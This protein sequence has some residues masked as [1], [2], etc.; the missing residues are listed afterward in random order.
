M[1]MTLNTAASSIDEK[2]RRKDRFFTTTFLISLIKL[3]FKA[4][5]ES[6]PNALFYMR[7]YLGTELCYDF[8][9]IMKTFFVL[10]KYPRKRRAAACLRALFYGKTDDLNTLKQILY[11][12]LDKLKLDRKTDIEGQPLDLNF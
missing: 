7:V 11:K 2:L 1:K 10:K 5:R 6:G 3:I 4:A 9:E 12:E 8:E